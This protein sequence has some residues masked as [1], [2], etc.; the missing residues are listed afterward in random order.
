MTK[1]IRLHSNSISFSFYPDKLQGKYILDLGSSQ[2]PKLSQ[3]NSTAFS[4]N[5][6]YDD[7]TNHA[8]D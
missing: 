2:F 3:K 1:F 4:Q 6:F 8:R 7:F 5:L